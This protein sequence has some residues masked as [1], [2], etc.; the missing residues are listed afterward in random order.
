LSPAK[1]RQVAGKRATRART[2]RGDHARARRA[3]RESHWA[4]IAWGPG[5][6]CWV[7]GLKASPLLCCWFFFFFFDLKFSEIVENS[8]IYLK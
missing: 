6:Q 1:H 7:R 2:V 8:K 5:Q 3:G 4:E